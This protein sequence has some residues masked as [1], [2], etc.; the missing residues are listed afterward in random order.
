MIK[1]GYVIMKSN[2]VR[3]A[4][5]IIC[6]GFDLDFSCSVLH[7]D[8]V[9]FSIKLERVNWTLNGVAHPHFPIFEE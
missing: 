9:S 5:I 2:R 7:P 4:D 6:L 1:Y 8:T 3:F